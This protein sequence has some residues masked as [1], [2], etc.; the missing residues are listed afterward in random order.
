MAQCRS[1]QAEI[2]WVK[3]K[4]GKMMPVNPTAVWMGDPEGGKRYEPGTSHFA[5]CPNAADHR[6]DTRERLQE[7]MED[8]RGR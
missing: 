1:C 3:Q 8:R 6:Q 7:G 5:T 2:R 4:S